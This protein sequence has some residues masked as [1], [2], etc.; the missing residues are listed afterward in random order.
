MA[1]FGW[2]IM[3][4]SIFRNVK[5]GTAGGILIYF[6]SFYVK[7]LIP[8]RQSSFAK[9]VLS[10]F[11]NQALSM[12]SSVLWKLEGQ[13]GASFS[14]TGASFMNYS[15]NTYFTYCFVGFLLFTFLGFYLQNV[16][17]Q[18][19]GI[20][21]HPLFLFNS[22]RKKPSYDQFSDSEDF[23]LDSERDPNYE[24]E[25]LHLKELEKQNQIL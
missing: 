11:P 19:F 5:T 9:S 14:T 10:L 2:I 6:A 25:N 16:L 15:H 8:D 1:G 7:Y 12:G 22:C 24:P 23:E 3:F 18:E 20:Q 4:V 13:Q 17:K 21:K